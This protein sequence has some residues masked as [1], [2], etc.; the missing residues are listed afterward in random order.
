[1]VE[2]LQTLLNKVNLENIYFVN[3]IAIALVLFFWNFIKQNE[4]FKSV[5]NFYSNIINKKMNEL[6]ECIDSDI[7]NE[8]EKKFF[9]HRRKVL[10]LKKNL[11]ADR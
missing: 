9:R 6:S 1:M 4:L 8:N 5:T 2:L 10:G 7:Y 11:R 3:I